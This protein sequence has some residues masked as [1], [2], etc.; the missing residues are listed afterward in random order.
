MENLHGCPDFPN[1]HQL[2][3]GTLAPDAAETLVEHVSSCAQ[4][5]T[6]LADLER[7]N[8]PA[9]QETVSAIN[10]QRPQVDQLVNRILIATAVPTSQSIDLPE[11]PGYRILRELGH[12][13][14]GT[15]YLAE[16]TNLR[17]MVALKV[18]KPAIA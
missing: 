4:C 11:I 12:G 13:G 14:M 17:R 15:G 18:M 8:Q 9:E 2:L 7:A 10:L 5:A 16:E 6:A 1:L 3:S